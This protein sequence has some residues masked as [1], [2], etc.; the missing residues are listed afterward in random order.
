MIPNEF[1][2]HL[3]FPESTFK[4][5]V[6]NYLFDTFCGMELTTGPNNKTE[7]L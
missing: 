4:G 6:Y 3:E 7:G 5:Y 1:W 2:R